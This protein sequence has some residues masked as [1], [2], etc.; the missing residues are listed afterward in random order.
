MKPHPEGFYVLFDEVNPKSAYLLIGDS[1]KDEEAAKSARIYFL[2]I[3][4]VS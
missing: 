4:S 2:N 1:N 3:R